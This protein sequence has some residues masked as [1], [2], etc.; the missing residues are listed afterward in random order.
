MTFLPGPVHHAAPS[1]QQADALWLSHSDCLDETNLN[2]LP[3]SM[4]CA[5][6][7]E[8]ESGT[9][10]SVSWHRG[11]IIYYC[12]WKYDINSTLF[13]Q[14]IH[15]SHTTQGD[16]GS[17]LF[18]QVDGS[19]TLYGILFKTT[20]NPRIAVYLKVEDYL[21]WIL[22]ETSMNMFWSIYWWHIKT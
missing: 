22:Y 7:S 13:N 14:H 3:E 9:I 11:H 20:S 4:I 8:E 12:I 2:Q 6:T 1:L 5:K 15:I 18:I 16:V 17:P 19:W 21:D 10:S